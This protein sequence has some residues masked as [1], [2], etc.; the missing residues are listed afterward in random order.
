M[1][2]EAA[3]LALRSAPPRHDPVDR[4]VRHHGAG[5]PRQDQRQR[6]PRRAGAAVVGGCGRH[7]SAS[8]RSAVGADHRR[9]RSAA[10]W[11]CCPT[12]APACPA[13][14]TRPDGGDAAVGAAVRRRR[15]RDRRDHRRCSDAT[16]EFV[17]RW[18]TPGDDHSKQ[19][20][21]RFGEYAYLP[22]VEQAV[23]RRA[24]GAGLTITEIDHVDRH[25]PARPGRRGGPHGRSAPGPTPLVDD[26]ADVIGNTGAAHPALLLADVLDR[27]E[28]GQTIA[29]VTLADGCR[30]LA[31]AHHRRP[32]PAGAGR[33]PVGARPDRRDAR[34]PRLRQLPHL[35]RPAPPRAAAPARARPP[36]RPAVAAR[37]TPGSTACS[38]RATR[39]G[40]C[41]CRPPG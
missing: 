1:G 33:A 10:G 41:T 6:H 25:R 23:D 34:R 17:D 11:P 20:E 14:P 7:R 18:R 21:E 39:P 8:V 22:L 31:A 19:W 24:E 36:G 38:A 40:S 26:L 13:A 12:S 15:R 4:R 16:A 35:A 30:R 28:P 5:V 2:V 32:S 27:A 37:A 29:V 9:R 3:R